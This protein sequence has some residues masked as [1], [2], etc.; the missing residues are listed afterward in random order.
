METQHLLHLAG[1]PSPKMLPEAQAASSTEQCHSPAAHPRAS[2]VGKP[3]Q[4]T[5]GKW[6]IHR[7]LGSFMDK[8]ELG[9]VWV[10]LVY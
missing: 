7:G 4:D 5:S 6:E 8:A 10:N 9:Q 3:H 1:L 2:G